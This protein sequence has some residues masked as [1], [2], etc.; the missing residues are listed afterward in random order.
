MKEV[1]VR[2]TQH[3]SLDLKE[4]YA[5]RRL[6]YYF[7]WRELK[8]RYKQTVVGVF[9]VVL[10]PFALA[11]IFSLFISQLGNAARY[12]VPYFIFMYIAL[13]FWNYFAAILARTS[14][15]IVAN[16]SVIRKVYFPSLVTPLS[17]IL[18]A[19]VDLLVTILIFA[20]LVLVTRT[21]IHIEGV[22]MF[23]PMI[24]LAT[25]TS[26]GVGLFFAALNVKYRDINH[27]LPFMVQAWFFATPVVY[28]F[29]IIP[30]N[31]KTLAFLNPMTSVTSLM[32]I[33]LF[34]PGE[35]FNWSWL[36]ISVISAVIMF[37]VG[38]SYFISKEKNFTENI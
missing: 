16:S 34:N 9:W 29:D 25:V 12:N 33:T 4:L 21:T 11:A 2:K 22:L 24:I 6:L 3:N 19:F 10:Q 23:I 20:I 13:L 32:R 31:L 14:N 15:S 35:Y 7:A 18:V 30:E 38:L 26:F 8:S 27:A 28:P 17:V 36:G 1:I 5:N 37:V